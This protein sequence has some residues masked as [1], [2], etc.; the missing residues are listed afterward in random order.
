MAGFQI[1][2]DSNLVYSNTNHKAAGV[3]TR[4]NSNTLCYNRKLEGDVEMSIKGSDKQR[5]GAADG[6]QII[7]DFKKNVNN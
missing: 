1:D 7:V 3:A 2:D 6:A 4:N 5:S